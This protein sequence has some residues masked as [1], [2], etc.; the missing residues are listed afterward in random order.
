MEL[1]EFQVYEALLLMAVFKMSEKIFNKLFLFIKQP[2][3][4]GWDITLCK[5]I[6]KVQ[7]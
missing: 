4:K 3:E 2:T 7:S 5:H 6:S 1:A